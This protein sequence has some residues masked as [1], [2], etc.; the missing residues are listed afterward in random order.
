[1]VSSPSN[2]L[3]LLK[4]IYRAMSDGTVFFLVLVRDVHLEKVGMR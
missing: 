2:G 4:T 1:M 3:L